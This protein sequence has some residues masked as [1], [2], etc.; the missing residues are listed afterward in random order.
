MKLFIKVFLF[1]IFFFLLLSFLKISRA[2]DFIF[3]KENHV[4]V[5]FKENC[6]LAEVAKTKEEILK[7]LM[8]RQKLDADKGMIFVFEKEGIYPFWMKNTLIS[9]DIIWIDGENQIVFIKKNAEPC[10]ELVC[11][12]IKPDK[13]SK[14]VLEV[15]AGI[16]EKINLQIG[17]TVVFSY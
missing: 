12:S 4:R 1:A 17:D 8:F 3:D 7:G 11:P 14:Y 10:P 16:S 6:F 2:P 5:C 15:S 13:K 9:L